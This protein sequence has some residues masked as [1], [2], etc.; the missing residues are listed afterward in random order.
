MMLLPIKGYPLSNYCLSNALHLSQISFVHTIIIKAR[1]KQVGHI[2]FTVVAN[3]CSDSQ[4]EITIN[5][6]GHFV[7]VEDLKVVYLCCN[8][9][10]FIEFSMMLLQ[11]QQIDYQQVS[12][13]MSSTIYVSSTL[14][15]EHI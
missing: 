10:I 12:L 9:I 11:L 8:F 6:Y 1:P 14:C 7:Q 15:S 13:Q 2:S 5:V 3:K 4:S